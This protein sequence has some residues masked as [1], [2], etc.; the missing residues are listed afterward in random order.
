MINAAG[1]GL[2]IASLGALFALV[3]T[4]HVELFVD[5]FLKLI[6]TGTSIIVGGNLFII[7]LRRWIK[8]RGKAINDQDSPLP[9]NEDKH[10]APF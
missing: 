1:V 8:K 6:G 5:I 2:I 9:K 7:F 4:Q 3:E 10:G